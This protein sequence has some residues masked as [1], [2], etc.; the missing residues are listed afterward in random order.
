MEKKTL[1]VS[2]RGLSGRLSSRRGWSGSADVWQA[3]AGVRGHREAGKPGVG[4]GAQ[5]QEQLD[6]D[7]RRN[8]TNQ[9]EAGKTQKKCLSRDIFI[10]KL[11][12]NKN[13]GNKKENWFVA[14]LCNAAVVRI[15]H[16]L[17]KQKQVHAVLVQSGFICSSHKNI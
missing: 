4:G 5:I 2:D 15:Y 12:Q 6:L 17:M 3:P 10:N 9:R 7:G 16:I 8:E 1:H 14:K 13:S 11:R